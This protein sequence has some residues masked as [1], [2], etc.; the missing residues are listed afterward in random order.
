MN[1]PICG[2]F[3]PA[4]SSRCTACGADFG[5]PDV[6][7]LAAAPRRPLTA[8]AGAPAL[9]EAALANDRVLFMSGAGIADGTSLRRVGLIGALLLFLGALCPVD[10]DFHGTKLPFQVLGDGPTVAMIVPLIL[11]A[12]VL[13]VA[14][15]RRGV[16][17][18]VGVAGVLA[19]A[20]LLVLLLGLTPFGK[21]ARTATELPLLTWLGV[22]IAGIGVSMRVLLPRDPAAPFIAV[23]GAALFLV[24][25]LLPH[26][27]LDPLVPIEMRGT[28]AESLL[29]AAY[30]AVDSKIGSV[31]LLGLVQLAPIA[32]LSLG[33]AL[34]FR[35]PTGLW[36]GTGNVLRIFALAI[37]LWLPVS[38]VV[39]A[40]NILGPPPTPPGEKPPEYVIIEGETHR[41]TDVTR[42]LLLGRARLA[43]LSAGAMFWLTAGA[44]ALYTQ[45]R[46]RSTRTG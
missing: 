25:G 36:D 3:S 37:V 19:A 28:D 5:D 11:A 43:V 44:A 10:L 38:F 13:A 6:M 45:L 35:R 31:L 42:A 41:V 34:S 4:G 26:D 33:A 1:C 8:P 21:Y 12:A 17:P 14:V 16:I 2:R 32:L 30:D 23:G 15:P 7:A 18:P 40:F 29:G 22:A 27:E 24:G 9:E 39:A 20:G 46:V